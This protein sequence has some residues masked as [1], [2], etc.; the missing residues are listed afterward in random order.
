MSSAIC[1]SAG[2]L[3]TARG[4]EWIVLSSG[5]TLLL[6]P[7]TGSE[8]D[9]ESII[10]EL[11]AEPIAHAAFAPPTGDRA[12][13]REAAVLLRDAL[14]LS[15][16]R[17]A[18]P[19]RSSGRINFE[20]RAYQLAPLMMA[21]RQEAE[22]LRAERAAARLG[23]PFIDDL[24]RNRL[25]IARHGSSSNGPALRVCRDGVWIFSVWE[26]AKR[27]VNLR[28]RCVCKEGEGRPSTVLRNCGTHSQDA[29]E[30]ALSLRDREREE[31]KFWKA[32]AGRICC[33]TMDGCPL[34]LGG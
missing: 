22:Q 17:G 4:R 34:D 13:P 33:G 6:R 28:R 12:G 15:L 7:L 23:D 26:T 31:V 3:V 25:T 11:E 21:L 16:R 14:R 19:F 30:L 1:F 32:L 20:P 18:G 5:D 9:A 24:A 8:E 27:P 29:V 2:E 10:P